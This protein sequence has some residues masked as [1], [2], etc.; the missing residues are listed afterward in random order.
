MGKDNFSWS[1][2]ALRFLMATLL[3]Y[4]TYNPEGYSFYHWAIKPL[5]EV[6][7]TSFG[8][9]NP[10]K[11]LA[12]IA[13]FAGWVVFIQATKRSLGLK[14]ALLA[15]AFFGGIVWVLIYWNVFTPRGTRAIS[16]IILIV[17]ALVLAMGLSWSHVTRRLTGQIDTDQIA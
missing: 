5:R 8:A 1:G 10:L 2:V 9:I 15:I 14:G 4:M 13:L 7:A 3:V 11:V 12:G 17:L 6:P 16:H